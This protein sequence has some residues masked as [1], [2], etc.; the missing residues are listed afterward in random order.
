MHCST[1]RYTKTEIFE[2]HPHLH[3][4]SHLTSF[5][6]KQHWSL[7]QACETKRLGSTKKRGE[8]MLMYT[9]RSIWLERYVTHQKK[10]QASKL[11]WSEQTNLVAELTLPEVLISS[12]NFTWKPFLKRKQR[13]T[14]SVRQNEANLESHKV[15][16]LRLFLNIPQKF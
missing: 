10:K 8:K 13:Q 1:Q 12:R 7:L 16:G 15:W 11:H 14:N 4:L 6:Y 3:K 9:V 5:L 2:P